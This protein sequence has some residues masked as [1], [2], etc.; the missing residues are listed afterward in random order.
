MAAK[1][2]YHHGHLQEAL[3][4]AALQVIAE[5]GAN[6]FTL[7]EVARRAGVSHNA[8]YR[9][10]ADKD[11]LLA[12]VAKQGF[13]ELNA[14]MLEAGRREKTPLRRLTGAGLAYVGFALRRPE[15]FTVMFEAAIPQ[16]NEEA[17]ASLMGLV[18]ECQDAGSLPAGDVLRE[19]LREWSMVHGVAKLATAKRLPFTKQAEILEFARFVI[20]SSLGAPTS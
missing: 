11:E 4:E 10:F 13:A 3:L 6:D 12:A 16:V 14:A 15:H 7:R 2:P 20:E 1:K 17:F 8:P 18:K 9:H 5:R 19:S